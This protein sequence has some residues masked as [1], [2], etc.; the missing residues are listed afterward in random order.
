MTLST[1]TEIA[2]QLATNESIRVRLL[3]ERNTAI[4]AARSVGIRWVEI[5]DACQT[6]NIQVTWERHLTTTKGTS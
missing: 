4:A 5:N 6:K 1:L 3:G 2:D